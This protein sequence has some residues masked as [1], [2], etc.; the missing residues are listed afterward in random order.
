MNPIE[1]ATSRELEIAQLKIAVANI[2]AAIRHAEE[3]IDAMRMKQISRSM[4]LARQE[5]LAKLEKTGLPNSA[6]KDAELKHWDAPAKL[7]ALFGAINDSICLL[8][9]DGVVLQA[10]PAMCHHMDCAPEQLAGKSCCELVHGNH[11]FI[12]NCPMKRMLASGHRERQEIRHGEGWLDITADPVFDEK[13]GLI[14]AVHIIRD[15]SEQKRLAIEREALL[16]EIQAAYFEIKALH[17]LLPIC[18]NCKSIRDHEGAWVQIESYIETRSEAQFSHGICPDCA[19]KLYPEY[20][21][22]MIPDAQN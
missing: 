15:I 14:G 10:N 22:A 21:K 7:D 8:D 20:C 17:G 16:Q 12:P 2:D 18:A 3:S 11:G 5:T 9:Q 19:K 1:Q 4:E 13:G 6:C